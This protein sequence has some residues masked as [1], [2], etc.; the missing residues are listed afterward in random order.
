MK[1][2]IIGMG[3]VGS[4]IAY[5]LLLKGLSEELV[6]VDKNENVAVGEALDLQHAEAFVDHQM[7]IHGGTVSDTAKSDIIIITSSVPWDPKYTSRFDIGK[8]NYQ[9]FQK[10]IPPLAKLSPN[11]KMLIITNPVDVMTYHAIKLSE[12][13]S[14]KVFGSGT[15]IDSARFRTMLSQK[16]GIHPDDLRAYILGEHGDSQ[17]PLFSMATVGGTLIAADQESIGVYQE[18]RKAGHQVMAKKGHT[19]YA[20]GLSTAL[21]IEAIVWNSQRTMPITSLVKGFHGVEDV[22]LSLPT[23]IGKDGISQVIEP[24]LTENEILAFH[25]SAKLV[26]GGINLSIS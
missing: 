16:V 5:T 2:S 12:F 19:N 23:V 18:T 11:S 15:L 8:D 26:K 21:I 13:D 10:I 17:F 3:R 22:C 20:I 9:L 6:L 4:A 24:V 14:S 25:E 7:S 1:I